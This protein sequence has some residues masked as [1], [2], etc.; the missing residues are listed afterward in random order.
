[1]LSQYPGLFQLPLSLLASLFT[2]VWSLSLIKSPSS[3]SEKKRENN[4]KAKQVETVTSQG[5][6][7]EIKRRG[8]RDFPK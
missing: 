5:I 4:R 8:A 2:V 7:N 1:M 6:M 3:L